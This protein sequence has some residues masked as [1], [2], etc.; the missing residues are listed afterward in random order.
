ML[1]DSISL[2]RDKS[3]ALDFVVHALLERVVEAVAFAR[4]I[5][6]IAD[7]GLDADRELVARIAG[8]SQAFRVIGNEFECHGGFFFLVV[9]WKTSETKKT[10]DDCHPG[11]LIGLVFS[12]GCFA[13]AATAA[14]D[15]C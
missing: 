2:V 9:P 8:K 4:H 14:V 6:D 1:S 13:Q 11:P 12:G 5:V 3:R 15:G 7:L 10:P